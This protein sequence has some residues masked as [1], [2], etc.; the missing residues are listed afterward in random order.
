MELEKPKIKYRR[1]KKKKILT[2]SQ[3]SSVIALKRFVGFRKF[4]TVNGPITASMWG[5]RTAS[6]H[7]SQ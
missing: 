3:S 5:I 6:L 7:F 4:E 2:A 1:K